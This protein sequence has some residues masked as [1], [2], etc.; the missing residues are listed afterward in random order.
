M[1]VTLVISV[2]T[3]DIPMAHDGMDRLATKYVSVAV[4]LR[5]KRTPDRHHRR[6]G[7][8]A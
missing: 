2:A 5:E 3:S 6:P 8:P 1:K 4:C 7:R